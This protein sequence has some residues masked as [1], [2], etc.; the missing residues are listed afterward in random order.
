MELLLTL[1][2][3]IATSL[4]I[5]PVMIRLAPWLG[6]VDQP[7]ARKVHQFPIPRVGGWGIVFGALVAVVLWA[8]FDPLVL[9]YIFGVCV[10]F[11]FGAWDDRRELGHYTK[12]IGQLIA[13][14]PIVTIAGLY[15]VDFPFIQDDSVIPA[16]YAMLF[17]MLALMGMANAINHSDGLDGLAGGESTLSLVAIAFLAYLADG[18]LAVLIALAVL[19]GLFGF[20]RYNTHPAVVFMGDNG[21][22]AIGF[23]LGV[24]AILLTQRIDPTLSPAVAVLLLG[25]PVADILYV[26]YQRI[27]EGNNWF[28]A[29]KNHVHHR[30][31]ERGFTHKEAVVIIYSIQIGFVGSG[32]LLRHASD[33]LL[34]GVY[35]G[36]CAVVFGFLSVAERTGWRMKRRARE[37][38]QK[39]LLSRERRKTLL[40]AAPRRFLEIAI[41]GY[42]VFASIG[43][44]DLT[45]PFGFVALGLL[46]GLLFHIFMGREPRS[47]ARR[48]L[49]FGVGGL[50]VYLSFTQ[51]GPVTALSQ[52]IHYLFFALVAVAVIM[53]IHF[54][55]GQRK[56]EFEATAMD[57]LI[58]L[59][60]LIPLL[61]I[62]PIYQSSSGFLVALLV[63]MY[64]L[65]LLVTERREHRAFIG[66][67]AVIA[68]SVLVIKGLLV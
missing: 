34:A 55:P 23:S 43:I 24:L 1:F 48:S 35:L 5:V 49:L 14:L 10:L 56:L 58:V 42:L 32:I 59:L 61:V 21:S 15:V 37:I 25:L 7:S 39:R 46:A 11:V 54:N 33:W 64:A 66:P 8:P 12:F 27:S 3:A 18:D 19:G 44:N 29:T 4:A 40:V 17:S 41:P 68:A 45:A 47:L 22:Q 63:L 30:L 2:T 16:G 67:S 9:S 62:G 28:K 51:P 26:L 20:L 65:E 13:V 50:V 36:G 53:A 60:V 57:Y 6:M 38:I 52:W 31:I